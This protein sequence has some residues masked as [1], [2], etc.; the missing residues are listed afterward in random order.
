MIPPDTE[1]SIQ[2]NFGN[3]IDVANE[4]THWL[5]V[6]NSQQA[7]DTILPLIGKLFDVQR[8]LI[9]GRFHESSRGAGPWLDGAVQ[10]RWSRPEGREPTHREREHRQYIAN[11]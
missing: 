10:T 5:S 1:K 4:I 6:N 2:I 8:T 3:M 9:L 11:Q 7:F